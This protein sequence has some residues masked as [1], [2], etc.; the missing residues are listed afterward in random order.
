MMKQTEIMKE[1]GRL[2]NHLDPSE[3][4]KYEL[5][6]SKGKWPITLDKERYQREIKAYLKGQLVRPMEVL[7]IP[8]VKPKKCLSPYMIF[9]KE[10]KLNL[11]RQMRP[12]IIEENANMNILDVMREIGK[13][14]RTIEDLDRDYFQAKSN[15]DKIRFTKEIDSFNK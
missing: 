3:K 9:V 14:W 1:V 6:A 10:V 8:L 12:K 13:R 7:P 4:K 2:W 15:V 11:T 5:E